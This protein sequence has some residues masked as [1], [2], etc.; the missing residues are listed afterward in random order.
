MN[1]AL[2]DVTRVS[3]GNWNCHHEKIDIKQK[4]GNDSQKTSNDP[5]KINS[6]NYF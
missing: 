2:E 1:P 3:F 5:S 4:V 6:E